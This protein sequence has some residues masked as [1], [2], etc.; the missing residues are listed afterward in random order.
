MV[1]KKMEEEGN[2]PHPIGNGHRPIVLRRD[3]ESSQKGHS[4]Q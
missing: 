2:N 1:E 4:K 3:G